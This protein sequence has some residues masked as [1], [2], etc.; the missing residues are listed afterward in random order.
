MHSSDS[1]FRGLPAIVVRTPTGFRSL[2]NQLSAYALTRRVVER[3][4][5]E[6]SYIIMYHVG[7]ATHGPVR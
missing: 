7:M 6:Y 5:T 4:H 3:L 2:C 1:F